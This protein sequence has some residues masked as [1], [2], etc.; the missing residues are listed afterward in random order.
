[1]E[2]V[3]RGRDDSAWRV[4]APWPERPQWSPSGE[5][6]TTPLLQPV[7]GRV[8]AAAMEPVRRGRDDSGPASRRESIRTAAMEP[9]RRGRDDPQ[10]DRPSPRPVR[11]PQWSPS[12][13]DGTTSTGTAS[14]PVWPSRNGAR[15]E[16]TGRPAVSSRPPAGAGRRNGARP[17]RTGRHPERVGDAVEVIAAMEPVRRG[18]DDHSTTAAS[19]PAA[20]PQWSPSGEDG[21]TPS[22]DKIAADKAAA[23]MEPVR[24]G[25]DD[26]TTSGVWPGYPVAAMEPVRRGRDDRN[27]SAD[28]PATRAPQWSPSGEDGTTCAPSPH[29]VPCVRR[30][31]A[32]PER[33]G[34]QPR[35]RRS[36]GGAQP[37]QWSPSGEDGTTSQPR[38]RWP[39]SARAAM[40]PVRR[41]R[42]DR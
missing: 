7:R 22:A 35:R 20:A 10:R 16:R 32:R 26:C 37:P 31:G 1:M 11:M 18:R 3:R 8:A 13:E 27:C 17:E 5:D 40:E 12:G 4:C 39:A 34:R 38:R 6:G 15:P 28:I 29:V 23:A 21:T 42:D 9:V 41:G 30:N 36:G 14:P 25:R 24:R 2:P 19:S 33:T